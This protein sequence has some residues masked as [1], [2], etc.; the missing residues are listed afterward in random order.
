M[1]L[2]QGTAPQDPDSFALF[3]RA[4]SLLV[5]SSEALVVVKHEI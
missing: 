4:I 3:N 2:G 5:F 1:H